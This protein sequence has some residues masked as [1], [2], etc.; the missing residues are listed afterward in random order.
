MKKNPMDYCPICSS[1]EEKVTEQ[2]L[3]VIQKKIYAKNTIIFEQDDEA[4]GLYLI[5]KGT[6]KISKISSNGKEVVLGLLGPGKTF[7]EGSLLGQPRQ[8]DMAST[9]ESC[10]V[11]Y[12]PKQELQAVLTKHPALYQSVVSSL[13]R[14]MANLNQVIENIST[15]SA[16]DRVINYLDRLQTEQQ[17]AVVQ[18][19]GKKHEIALMLGLRPETFSRAL[20]ELEEQQLIKMSHKQIQILKSIR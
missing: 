13:V 9:S 14:W 12:L 8:T 20:A 4:K 18:L 11:F 10:E 2:I 16:Q 7:G 5:T 19:E 15:P 3:S 17:T 1:Q 6:V